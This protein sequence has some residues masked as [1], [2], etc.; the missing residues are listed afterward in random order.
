MA[1]DYL[2]LIREIQ[3]NRPYNLLGWSFGG[4]VAHAIAT[5]L[6]AMGEEVSILALLDSYP[7]VR[8]TAS[9][10]HDDE[11]REVIF[12]GVADDSIRAMLDI[13][14]REGDALSTLNEEHYRAIKDAYTN[15]IRL[16]TQ[17]SPRR[18]HGDILLFVATKAKPSCRTTSG[19]PTSAADQGPPDRLHARYDDG[20]AAG[21]EDRPHSGRR[22]RAAGAPPTRRRTT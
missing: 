21:R 13:L 2:R 14:R 4:L 18:F 9:R 12:A 17:F 16:M 8:D 22:A 5:Q 6:Q 19:A 20:A 11:E 15:N 1:A 10:G 7:A 3:P